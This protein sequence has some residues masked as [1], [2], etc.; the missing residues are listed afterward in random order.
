MDLGDS[1]FRYPFL[2]VRREGLEPPESEDDGF[3]DRSATNYGLPTL[4]V[5]AVS[6]A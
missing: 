4:V 6:L 5:L 2:K 1:S 3:T